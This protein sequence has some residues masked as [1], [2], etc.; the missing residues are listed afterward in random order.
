MNKLLSG[1]AALAAA[2]MLASGAQAAD[3][4]SIGVGGFF[5]GALSVANQD[6]DQDKRSYGV[7]R[8]AEIIFSGSTTIDGEFI[9]GAGVNVQLEGFTDHND[10]ID[11]S[12]MWLS[13]SFGQLRLGSFDGAMAVMGVYPA[14]VGAPG[15]GLFFESHSAVDSTAFGEGAFGLGFDGDAAKIAWFSPTVGGARV[16]VSFTPE[17]ETKEE[18]GDP[19][20]AS[21]DRINRR[22][23]ND[24]GQQSEVVGIG[25]NWSGDFGGASVSVGAGYTAGNLEV[26]AGGA[27]DR[28]EWIVGASASLMGITISGNYSVDNNAKTT[29]GDR[30][31]IAVGATYSGMGPLTYGVRYGLTSREQGA[32]KAD[33]D[34]SAVSVGV[35]MPLGGGVTFGS[36]V[37]FWDLETS[38]GPNQG[39]VGVIGT[40]IRF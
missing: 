7:V 3:P 14:G 29:N 8:D 12:F 24:A 13:G 34:S 16:G 38:D 36:E 28:E 23:T 27:T 35:S 4:I 9:Q 2:G 15:H 22:V 5:H 18:K 19:Q 32:G 25:G 30:T 40:T 20:T 39:T 10:Q 26:P 33:L 21:D 1:T 17:A 6:M 31:T 11:E 37:Q